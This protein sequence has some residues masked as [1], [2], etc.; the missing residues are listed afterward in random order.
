MAMD[1]YTMHI[2]YN[3]LIP[4]LDPPNQTLNDHLDTVITK[5]QIIHNFHTPLPIFPLYQVLELLAKESALMRDRQLL[6]KEVEFLRRQLLD[7][8]E[9]E[10]THFYSSQKGLVDGILLDVK[11]EEEA[12]ILDT[13][14]DHRLDEIPVLESELIIGLEDL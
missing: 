11:G 14:P 2:W 13:Q 10:M 12:K 3:G 5:C 1:D 8:N 6:A 7:R 4:L 9:A